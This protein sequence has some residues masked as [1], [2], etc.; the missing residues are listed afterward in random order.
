MG[1][2]SL[3]HWLVVLLIVVVIFGTKRL[4]GGA[5]DVGEAVREFKKGVRGDDEEKK[6]LLDAREDEAARLRE[7]ERVRAETDRDDRR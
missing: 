1:S 6:R 2:F 5:R 3:W 4:T 7:A